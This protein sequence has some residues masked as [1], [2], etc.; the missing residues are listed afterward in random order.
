M[1]NSNNNSDKE[2]ADLYFKL[3]SGCVKYK[4]EQDKPIDCDKF[5]TN[6]EFYANKSINNK[7]NK[8]NKT[9]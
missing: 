6:L 5:Y 2:M 8:D 3:Y 9:N 4:K 7:D 1:E